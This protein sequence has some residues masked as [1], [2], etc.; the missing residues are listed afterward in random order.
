MVVC[1]WLRRM[2]AKFTEGSRLWALCGGAVVS[3]FSLSGL[4]ELLR[5][6]EG[7][8][9][10]EKSQAPKKFLP[11]LPPSLVVDLYCSAAVGTLLLVVV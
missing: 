5:V 9:C 10:R 11:S 1:F 2:S 3:I 8:F 6:T 7:E 4:G